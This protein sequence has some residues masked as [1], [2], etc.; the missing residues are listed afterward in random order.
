MRIRLF[1]AASAAAILASSAL[2]ATPPVPPAPSQPAPADAASRPAQPGAAAADLST[3]VKPGDQHRYSIVINSAMDLRVPDIPGFEQK[4]QVSQEVDFVLTVKEHDPATGTT[5]EVKYERL[6][7]SIDSANLQGSFDSA[8]PAP[9]A[10]EDGEPQES[11]AAAALRPVVGTVLTVQVDPRGKVTEVFGGETLAGLDFWGQVA[12]QFAEREIVAS[13]V[14]PIISTR[15]AD[16][17]AEI[18]ETWT[19]I[20]TLDDSPLGAFRIVTNHTLDAVEGDEATITLSGRI[21]AVPPP[22]EEPAADGDDPAAETEEPAV[23]PAFEIK[24][25]TN[26]GRYVWDTAAGILK[27][28]KQDQSV[29]MNTTMQG[30]KVSID[31]RTSMH[32]TRK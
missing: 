11:D 3:R 12:R 29:T 26:S 13:F 16:G 10:G 15:R 18:G 1:T 7:F 19:Y 23:P 14:E 22:G 32:L 30:M 4:Q 17:E 31:N 27:S 28:L 2:A 21:E 5:L 20:D 9:E 25:S 8:A 24:E 6:K